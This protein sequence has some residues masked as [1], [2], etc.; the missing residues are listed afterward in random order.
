MPEIINGS[1]SAGIIHKKFNKKVLLIY[2]ANIKTITK[3]IPLA[4]LYLAESLLTKN[5]DPI[6]LDLQVDNF[7]PIMLKDILCV[8]ITTLTGPQILYGLKIAETIRA[9]NPNIPIIWGGIHPSITY[10]QTIQHPLVDYIVYGE[11]EVTFLEL[12]EAIDKKS[13]INQIPGVVYK[14]AGKIIVNTP[15]PFINFNKYNT[16]PYDLLSLSKY[17]TMDRFEYQSS[18]GCPFGC[19]YCYNKKYNFFK[20]RHKDSKIVL[21]EL[22]TIK[23]RF[24]SIILNLVDDEFFINKQRAFEIIKGMIERNIIFKWRNINPNRYD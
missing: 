14:E 4:L 15:R 17:Q 2:P 5:Y 12:V 1:N 23:N 3:R 7:N 11:G 18:R 6:I 19:I 10:E 21:D 16:L 13:K 8:G 22:E 9:I 24:H 20:W